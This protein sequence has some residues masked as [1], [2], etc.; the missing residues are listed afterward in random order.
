MSMGTSRARLAGAMKQLLVH[1]ELVQ[2]KWDDPVSADFEKKFVR[3]LEPRIRTAVV[4]MEKMEA[5]L[6]QVRRDCG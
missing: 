6:A 1:W 5:V 4:A 3:T 2:A